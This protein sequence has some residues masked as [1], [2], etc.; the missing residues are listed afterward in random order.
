MALFLR[1]YNGGD[2]IIILNYSLPG[3]KYLKEFLK[4]KSIV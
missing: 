4:K 3:D 1:L 2:S